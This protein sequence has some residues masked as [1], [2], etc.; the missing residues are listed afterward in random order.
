[1]RGF[2]ASSERPIVPLKTKF[3]VNRNAKNIV[4]KDATI[5]QEIA[6]A[7]LLIGFSI[8]QSPFLATLFIE[9]ELLKH[10]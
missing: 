1:M 7:K 10:N 2:S 6:F 5:L 3:P 8:Y 4:V 9:L